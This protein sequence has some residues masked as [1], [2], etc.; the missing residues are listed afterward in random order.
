M[1]RSVSLIYWTITLLKTFLLPLGK[2]G[3]RT[4]FD[5]SILLEAWSH[6]VFARMS[7][8]TLVLP[9][10]MRFSTLPRARVA[11]HIGILSTELSE[12]KSRADALSSELEGS[13]KSRLL[14]VADE[15]ERLKAD[16]VSKDEDLNL[17]IEAL[18]E[19]DEEIAR[20]NELLE[21]ERCLKDDLKEHAFD[22]IAERDQALADV[23][24]AKGEVEKL[25]DRVSGL[26]AEVTNVSMEKDEEAKRVA[27]LTNSL[28]QVHADIHVLKE[29]KSGLLE[30][31]EEL[32]QIKLLSDRENQQKVEQEILQ[33]SSTSSELDA[34]IQELN[35]K[36]LSTEQNNAMLVGEKEALEAQ[37]VSLSSEMQSQAISFRQHTD[38]EITSLQS[39]VNDLTELIKSHEEER[40][41]NTA[42]TTLLESRIQDLNEEKKKLQE[43][44]DKLQKD[45]TD[46]DTSTLIKERDENKKKADQFKEKAAKLLAKCKQQQKEI[47]ESQKVHESLS[48]ELSKAK[49]DLESI[50]SLIS[51]KEAELESERLMAVEISNLQVT[52]QSR[53][54][55]L[56]EQVKAHEEKKTEHEAATAL[57]ESRIQDLNE[58]ARNQKKSAADMATAN[59]KLIAENRALQ[60]SYNKLLNDKPGDETTLIKERDE[61]KKKADQ[62]KEK[63]TKLLAKCKQQQKEIEEGKKLQESISNDLSKAK[64][65][66]ESFE[67]AVGEKETELGSAR[68]RVAELE[69]QMDEKDSKVVRLEGEVEKWQTE[70]MEKAE[71]LE[72]AERKMEELR[73]AAPRED[74]AEEATEA[75][76]RVKGLED[77]NA[78]LK[79]ERSELYD[80][81]VQLKEEISQLRQDKSRLTKFLDDTRRELG[82]VKQ[83]NIVSQMM[84]SH[85]LKS[86]SADVETDSVKVEVG[87]IHGSTVAVSVA[88]GGDGAWDN[89]SQFEG[90][91]DG[92]RTP[93]PEPDAAAASPAADF[94]GFGD[95]DNDGWG[96]GWREADADA[97]GERPPKEEPK[98]EPT[99]DLEKDEDGWGDWGDP[100]EAKQP[101]EEKE[102]AEGEGWGGWGDDDADNQPAVAVDPPAVKTEA[103][104]EPEGDWGGWGEDDE[105]EEEKK[106]PEKEKKDPER[107]KS[108]EDAWGGWGDDENEVPAVKVKEENASA[109]ESQPV[110]PRLQQPDSLVS[111]TG[112]KMEDDGWGD[113]GWAGFDQEQLGENLRLTT[114]TDNNDNED[115]LKQVAPSGGS[116]E[117]LAKVEA[118]GKRPPSGKSA[119]ARSTVSPQEFNWQGKLLE[120]ESYIESLES[121]LEVVKAKLKSLEDTLES[122]EMAREEVQI[123]SRSMEGAVEKLTSEV[124]AKT[125]VIAEMEEQLAAVKD[126]HSEAKDKLEVSNDMIEDYKKRMESLSNEQKSLQLEL[127]ESYNELVS[128]RPLKDSDSQLKTLNEAVSTLK[129]EKRELES[130]NAKAREELYSSE[131]SLKSIQ[132]QIETLENERSDLGERLSKVTA[133]RDSLDTNLEA[134]Q[135]ALDEKTREM[136]ELRVRNEELEVTFTGLQNRNEELSADLAEKEAEADNLEAQIV[137]LKDMLKDAQGAYSIEKMLPCKT[138]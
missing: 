77:S 111:S 129:E 25:Q 23:Q 86:V 47:D 5:K 1:L 8:R 100:D 71:V 53:N 83:A 138:S 4:T 26:E 15:V 79:T 65:D 38:A 85:L 130:E 56:T 116:A 43:S 39:Q 82:A 14:E 7:A 63:A 6:F 136:E 35:S 132:G 74:V 76:I 48:N 134:A 12:A 115:G 113:D 133:R 17:K 128:L 127:T 20:V 118:G 119:S 90:P 18:K 75:L 3:V 101:Q 78:K 112:Q 10:N 28:E 57:L 104:G 61:S 68:E 51:E 13:T 93:N 67:K 32:K 11:I 137:D 29:E 122:N 91:E 88:S 81:Q 49:E 31:I 95:D 110:S 44:C 126:D 106:D 102:S 70:S 94:G 97:V 123:N 73:D 60:E 30:Q 55:A 96:D 22:G 16:L 45:K 121:D 72:K 125:R 34:K 66:L 50:K 19:K 135:M 105:P 59:D 87:S 42:A 54:N 107:P 36:I 124:E 9:Y 37:V 92:S 46:I 103:P 109:A 108:Q 69:R 24:S 41:E 84:E 114:S 98:A 131:N 2:V 117:E 99:K 21:D 62:F 120:K 52:T 89:D 58:Q 40:T 64:E 80:A 27:S 33:Q